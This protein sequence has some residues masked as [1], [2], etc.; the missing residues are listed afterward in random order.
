MRLYYVSILIGVRDL[1]PRM[2]ENFC[3]LSTRSDRLR[4]QPTQALFSLTVLAHIVPR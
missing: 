3:C 2:V 4:G 1:I